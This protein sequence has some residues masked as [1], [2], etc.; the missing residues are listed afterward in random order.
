MFKKLK[1]KNPLAF[2]ESK[3][4]ENATRKTAAMYY[5]EKNIKAKSGYLLREI[6]GESV[7]IPI[8]DN[9]AD[10]C[11]IISANTSAVFLWKMLVVGTTRD[12]MVKALEN[13]F[14]IS[15]DVAAA[16]VYDFLQQLLNREMLEGA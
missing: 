13:H 9:I 2:Q 3:I 5:G 6:A 8:G 12:D 15:K 16:D 4:E 10:F 7:I 11:G 14:E 1:S